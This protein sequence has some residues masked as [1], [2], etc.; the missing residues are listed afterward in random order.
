MSILG[1]EWTPAC[2]QNRR[3]SVI[4]CQNV[5]FRC[6]FSNKSSCHRQRYNIDR[7]NIE[8]VSNLYKILARLNVSLPT[9]PN[10]A[11]GSVLR[12]WGE[13]GLNL[14]TT[15]LRGSQRFILLLSTPHP[16]SLF[17]IRRPE[18]KGGGGG[19]ELHHTFDGTAASLSAFLGTTFSV[20]VKV[21]FEGR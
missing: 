1:V 8:S 13:G 11:G 18:G 2:T 17:S 21:F 12:F 19:G 10:S 20:D 15:L 6:Q 16:G 3:T 7:N 14:T 4:R 9:S 5:F